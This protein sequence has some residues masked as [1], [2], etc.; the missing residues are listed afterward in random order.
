MQAVYG[1]FL[2]DISFEPA[3]K[4]FVEDHNCGRRVVSCILCLSGL[5]ICSYPGEHAEWATWSQFMKDAAHYIFP[6]EVNIGRRYS[7]LGVDLIIAAIYISPATKEFLSSSLLLWLGK[8]SF[9]VYLI[10]GTLLRTVLCWSLYGITGQPWNGQPT[11]GNG[12]PALD[13]HGGPLQPQWIPIRAPWVVGISIPAW[14][15]LVYFCA[16]LWTKYV[17]SFCANMTHKLEK[18]MFQEDEKSEAVKPPND[19]PM[20]SMP[21]TGA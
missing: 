16:S 3:F 10:H 12:N 7:A 21:M 13:D 15:V 1:M 18:L 8:Q 14:T 17:D 19:L 20:S 2:S 6:P 9:A 5:L 11:H 4:Q